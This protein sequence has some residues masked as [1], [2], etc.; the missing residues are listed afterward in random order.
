MF[1][2]DLLI[3][4]QR[5]FSGEKYTSM[6]EAE[7][8]LDKYS[9]DQRELFVF[10]NA[11]PYKSWPEVVETKNGVYRFR[12]NEPMPTCAIGNYLGYAKYIKSE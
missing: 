1:A 4:I 2:S 6:K 12:C 9:E 5:L 7:L 10:T 3:K 11:T 8:T